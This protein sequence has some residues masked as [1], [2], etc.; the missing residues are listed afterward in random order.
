M[1]R[2]STCIG[3][4]AMLAF[5]LVGCGPRPVVVEEKTSEQP[6][7]EVDVN[8][9]GVEV[10]RTGDPNDDKGVD[11]EVGGGQGVQVEVEGK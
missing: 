2:I 9:N 1:K 6:A 7:V 3:A 10:E 5:L 8:R 11:V 4:V